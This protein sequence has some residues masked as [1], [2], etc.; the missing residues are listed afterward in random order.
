LAVAVRREAA[1]LA[2]TDVCEPAAFVALAER[3]AVDTVGA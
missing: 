2:V 3:R 1:G